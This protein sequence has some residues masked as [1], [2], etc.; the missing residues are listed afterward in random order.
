[1]SLRIQP[2]PGVFLRPLAAG[3]CLA[4][5]CLAQ[6]SAAHPAFTFMQA[7]FMDPDEAMQSATAFVA[8]ELPAG[9]S[10]PDAVA[11]LSRVD[12]HC[13]AESSSGETAC[14]SSMIVRSNGGTLGD[15]TWTVRL[16]CDHQG[17]LTAAR[18]GHARTGFAS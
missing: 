5:A 12:M 18:L 11:R 14:S 1:M 10:M 15:D 17:K 6:P 2:V 13:G 3:L 8:D 4:A 9:L 7:Q 16:R